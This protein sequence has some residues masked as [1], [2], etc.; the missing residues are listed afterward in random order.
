[1][2][3]IRVETFIAAHADAAS[4]CGGVGPAVAKATTAIVAEKTIVRFSQRYV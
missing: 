3:E 1:M 2:M 4:G